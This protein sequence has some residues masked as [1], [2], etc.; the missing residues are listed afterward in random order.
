VNGT[1]L[2]ET[3]RSAGIQ[4]T[5]G[6]TAVCAVATRQWWKNCRARIPPTHCFLCAVSY[7]W[8]KIQSWTF[9][10][11]PW[12]PDAQGTLTVFSFRPS[13]LPAPYVGN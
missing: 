3:K 6:S 4:M 1:S 13:F 5:G 10:N 7:R 12:K 2:T 11:I 8:G 9:I